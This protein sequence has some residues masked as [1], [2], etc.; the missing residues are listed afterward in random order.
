MRY[1]WW[2]T[3]LIAMAMTTAIPVVVVACSFFFF[4]A[5]V[6]QHLIDTVLGSYLSNSLLLALGTACGVVLLGV[7]T[8]WLSSM[9]VFPGRKMFEWMLLLPLA[10]PGYIIAYTYTG[11]LDVSGSVQQTL[12]DLTGWQYGEY[13]FPEIRSLAGAIVML[14]LTLYPY[15]YLLVRTTF[16]S[17]S[18]SALEVGSSLGL[19]KWQSF[20]RVAL[21]LAR[22]A[23]IAGVSLAL[24]EALADFGTVQYFGVQTFT[25]GIYR[26]WFGLGESAAASQIAAVLMFFVLF[27]IVVE[28]SSRM[29]MRFHHTSS[30][31]A[32]LP[33]YKLRGVQAFVSFAICA[34]PVLVGFFIPAGQ[35][36]YW[37][38]VTANTALDAS[39]IGLVG[40]SLMLAAIAA[41]S[42]GC[43]SLLL[44]YGKRA[45]KHPA[46]HFSATF[47]SMG[48]A[49]PGVVIALGTL[50]PFVWL[51]SLVQ[52]LVMRVSG[53]DTGLLISGSILILIFAY[54]VRFLSV[55]LQAID[56]GFAKIT[57]SID[58]AGRSLG[59]KPL[60]VL[61]KLHVPIMK[62]S[63]MTALILV[64]VDVLKE[65]PATLIL[66]PFNL[67]TLAI[68][69]YEMASDE[70]LADA[71]LPSILIVLTGV[72]PVIVLSRLS[73]SRESHKHDK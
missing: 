47:A 17:Q 65:L 8:A 19:N 54:N 44:G 2:R 69:A 13:Y 38:L 26:T 25:T 59:L 68:R 35:L 20:V 36:L 9:Y 23:L 1:R 67:N 71:G 3:I 56:S 70:R 37:S 30:K 4:D 39:F 42:I 14:S 21:P 40:N 12:R 10:F 52:S 16:V 27:I 45:S 53:Y 62:G 55:A 24:M 18:V 66:R 32:G 43:F 33:Q 72:V 58:E 61:F 49:V 73:Y 11:V 60:G 31:H 28:R 34:F 64:F 57:P 41:L 22:P 48:Y 6:W 7:P 46:L 15:V 50:I 51:D 5:Q 63:V 29:K